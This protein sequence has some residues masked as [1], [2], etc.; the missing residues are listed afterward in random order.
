LLKFRNHE[1]D[2]KHHVAE[3][4]IPFINEKGDRIIPET[5]NGIKLEKFVFD[6]FPFS[7]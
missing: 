3:K 2:L 4:K 5:N 1:K 6:V 7:T